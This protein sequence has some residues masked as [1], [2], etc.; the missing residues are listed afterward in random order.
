ML[1]AVL[2]CVAE[3]AGPKMILVPA[4]S[5]TI[6][7]SPRTMPMQRE[8]ARVTL[9]AFWIDETEVTNDQFAAFVEATGYVTTAERPVE[10]AELKAQLPADTPKP[11]DANL[12]PA[13]A[14]FTPPQVP[15]DLRDCR[16]WWTWTPGADWRHPDG[17]ESTIEG[18]GNHPVVQVSWDDAAA[19]ATW[20]G[21]R[22][23]TEDEW[24]RAARFGHDDATFTWGDEQTPGGTHMANIWQG[25]FPHGNTAED[26]HAAAAA[27]GSFPPNELGLHD[28]SGNVW[29]WTADRHGEHERVQ[30]GGSF[31]CHDSY[32]GAYRPSARATSTPD[33]SFPHVGFRCVRSKPQPEPEATSTTPSSP[34]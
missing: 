7:A 23:P 28:M 14:V 21:K 13:S 22:L 8:A 3:S 15:V 24:E 17:P 1:A 9:P 10:W 5:S 11:S 6:G 30:K 12:Q 34:E 27:V 25:P 19:Y 33:S 26:G 2:L 32:C 20:A 29:E 16:G 18:K 4:G 31:L